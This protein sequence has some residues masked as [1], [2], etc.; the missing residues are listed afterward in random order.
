MCSWINGVA[1]VYVSL[2][3]YMTVMM[4]CVMQAISDGENCSA[5]LDTVTDTSAT[6]CPDCVGKW[7]KCGGSGVPQVLACCDK[8]F[9]CYKANKNYMQ[10]RRDGSR[11]SSSWDGSI[12]P[13]EP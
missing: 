5:E 7:K 10:C 4:P 13:C 12:V 11:I 6:A 1:E 2:L 8:G 3:D 9:S